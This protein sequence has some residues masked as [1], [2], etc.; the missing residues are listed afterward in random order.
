MEGGAAAALFSFTVD[1]H[2][3]Q[4]FEIAQF[5]RRAATNER[6]YLEFVRTQSMSVGLYVLPA[7][8]ADGQQPHREDEVYVVT[9]GRAR[10]TA[11]DET[12]DVGPGDVLYV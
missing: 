11:G 1:R 10:F 6:P 9:A 4:R 5:A 3:S 2:V 7:G 12:R 8:G